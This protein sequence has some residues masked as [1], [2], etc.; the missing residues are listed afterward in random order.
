EPCLPNNPSWDHSSISVEGN[1]TGDSL[2]CFTIYNTGDP[3]DG[4]MDGTSEYRIFSN[5]ILVYTGTF[6]IAGGDS[7]VICW[8]ACGNTIR[9]EADQRP[10]HP[11]NSHPQ[12]NVEMCGDPPYVFGQIT[13]V[14]ED[15]DDDFIEISCS[16]VTS[17]WDPNDKQVIPEGITEEHFI[18]SAAMLE[19]QIRFQNTGTDTAFNIIIRDTLSEY[20]DITTVTPGAGSHPYTF[21]IFGSGILEWRFDNILLPDSNVNEPESHGFVNFSILQKPNNEI[22]TYISNSAGIIFDFNPP[23]MTNTVWNIVWKLPI[24]VNITAVLNNDIAIKI[25]PNP[26]TTFVT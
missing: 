19:Y 25:Y 7:L 23:V 22:G 10:G 18:D 21:N 16:Q 13:A 4:D 11:G 3:G 24:L 2:A 9:L 17:S 12:A 5:N 20:L 14:P 1:C 15:D 6:Q 8:A 26:S